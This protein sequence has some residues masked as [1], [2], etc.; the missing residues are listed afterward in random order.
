VPTASPAIREADRTVELRFAFWAQDFAVLDAWPLPGLRSRRDRASHQLIEGGE[1]ARREAIE[2][3]LPALRCGATP[4]E[5][6]TNEPLSA[7][8][9]SCRTCLISAATIASRA[10]ISR[11]ARVSTPEADFCSTER[12]ALKPPSAG[13]PA[14]E[15][16]G[17]HTAR[18][19]ARKI[20]R[21]QFKG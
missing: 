15:S 14:C 21:T 12:V 13:L 11:S 9:V 19:K 1:L 18:S 5:C 20:K 4:D 17:T 3:R 7:R 10:V 16:A 2:S 6:A 8:I